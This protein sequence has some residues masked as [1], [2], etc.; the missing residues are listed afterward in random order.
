LTKKKE[1]IPGVSCDTIQGRVWEREV[2]GLLDLDSG[3]SVCRCGVCYATHARVEELLDLKM[4]MVWVRDVAG[5]GWRI[6]DGLT[7]FCYRSVSESVNCEGWGSD[8]GA[9]SKD[10]WSLDARVIF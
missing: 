1:I 2:T 9:T 10:D 8:L 7:W 3:G 6:K 4:K 5:C